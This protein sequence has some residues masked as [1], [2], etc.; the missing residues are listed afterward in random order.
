M[1]GA[2]LHIKTG[3]PQRAVLQGSKKGQ[4]AVF[5]LRG[6]DLAQI[7]LRRENGIICG[8]RS[9]CRLP[10]PLTSFAGGK[11]TWTLGRQY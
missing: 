5:G 4:K 10:I 3:K 2:T 6:E 11:S 7:A 1:H 9:M 8:H